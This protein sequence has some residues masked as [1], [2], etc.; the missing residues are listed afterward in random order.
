M[1]QGLLFISIIIS[2]TT[3]F[4]YIDYMARNFIMTTPSHLLR[5]MQLSCPNIHLS[6]LDTCPRVL[7]VG[8]QAL[9][10][11]EKLEKDGLARMNEIYVSVL[12]VQTEPNK[13]TGRT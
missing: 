7:L 3:S 8:T 6:I 5:K 1:A 13:N 10:L 12:R 2:L 11:G 4:Y 9:A